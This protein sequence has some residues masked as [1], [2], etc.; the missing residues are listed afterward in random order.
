MYSGCREGRLSLPGF[1]DIAPIL[2]AMKV[3]PTAEAKTYKIC[4]QVHDKLVVLESLAKKFLEEPTT[5]DRAQEAI[6]LHSEE[7]NVGGDFV[8]AEKT[9]TPVCL[10]RLVSDPTPSFRQRGIPPAQ[11]RRR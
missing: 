5:K 8:L 6:Q 11:D 7:F 4:A 3:G 2:G 10:K 1:P 9:R